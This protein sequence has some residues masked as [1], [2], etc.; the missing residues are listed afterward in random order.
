MDLKAIKELAQKY[1][2]EQ[3]NHQVSELEET[4]KCTCSE[5]ADPGEV[6][7]DLLQALEVRKAVDSGQTLQEA[8]RDFSRRV[9][10]VLS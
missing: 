4:G 7:S 1:T 2:Q 6:M 10:S 9:R 5:K 3:L 8:I